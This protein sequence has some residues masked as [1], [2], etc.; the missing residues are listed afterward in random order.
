MILKGSQR[1]G[2]QGLAVHL[3]NTTDNEHVRVHELRGF[4]ADDLKGAFKEAEAVSRGTKCRQYLFSLSLSPPEQSRATE[5]DFARAIERI[6]ERLEL[7]GQ[8]RA[9]V[10][11]EKE[12][13]RHAHCVWSRIDVQTMT[14]RP[15][16][17]FKTK[18]QAIG[19]DLYL[20]HGWK[21]PRGF[22]N[23]AE[24][25]PTNFTLAE[26]QQAKRQGVDPRWIKQVLQDCWR[27]SNNPNAFS[28]ALEERG[29]FLAKGDKRGFIVLDHSAEIYS[30]PRYLGL[31]A[32]EVRDRLGGALK[33]K[34]VAHTQ[35]VI[36][37]RMTP[38]IRRYIEETQTR[39][40]KHA[41]ILEHDRTEMTQNHRVA[42]AQLDQQ[43][44]TECDAEK[45]QH[46]ARMPTGL[47]ALWDRLTGKYYE[48]RNLNEREAK[49]TRERHVLERQLLIMQQ[50]DRRAFLQT[51][52]KEL[53]QRQAAQLLLLRKDLGRYLQFTRN[54]PTQSMEPTLSNS[55]SF[56]R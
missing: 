26:W 4:T 45:R 29:F 36:G 25:N 14:A 52:F 23:A 44:R 7:Q 39:F 11:H 17:Y 37:E 3:L 33:L 16:P 18:L 34:G 49:S 24:R 46:A 42:R 22:D 50:L 9:V 43:Q 2:G 31:R 6:E 1:S 15:L 53:R 20:E 30:L 21:M 55:L 19:R 5:D 10:F 51:K 35:R 27:K 48:L 13:R 12:G 38:S 8:P 32:T 54:K 56:D 41:A 40:G 47:R 28:R